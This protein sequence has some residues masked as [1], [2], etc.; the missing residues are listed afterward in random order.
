MDL[1]GH[2][3]Y[4]TVFEEIYDA[5]GILTL[6]PITNLRAQGSATRL[7]PSAFLGMSSYFSVFSAETIDQF[8]G[9]LSYLILNRVRVIGGGGQYVYDEAQDAARYGGGAELL[10]GVERENN[11]GA[12]YHRLDREDDNG[13]AEVRGYLFQR[14]LTDFHFAAN[15]TTCFLDEKIYNVD[16]AFDGDASVGWRVLP[17]LDVQAT[18]VYRSGPYYEADY[19]GL[20]KI[21]YNVERTFQ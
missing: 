14:F 1:I 12:R 11:L 15:S 10:W 16:T 2:V 6:Y 7:Y 5:Q 21:A 19:R 20:L 4:D 17:R 13:Y 18:G 3:Y 9:E 8:E